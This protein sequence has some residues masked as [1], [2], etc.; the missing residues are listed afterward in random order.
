M[1]CPNP[2]VNNPRWTAVSLP[3]QHLS[4]IEVVFHGPPTA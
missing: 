3:D 4:L 2:S 1:K